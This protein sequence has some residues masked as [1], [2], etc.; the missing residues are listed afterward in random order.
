MLKELVG[1]GEASGADN[2][3]MDP[4][5]KAFLEMEKRLKGLT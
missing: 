4:G 5:M 2:A 1:E 3:V